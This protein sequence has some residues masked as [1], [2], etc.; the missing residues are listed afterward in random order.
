M[1]LIHD[2]LCQSVSVLI[3]RLFVKLVLLLT[4]L[5]SALSKTLSYR[6]GETYSVD[7]L[8]FTNGE[9]KKD[10]TVTAMKTSENLPGNKVY[11][12]HDLDGLGWGNLL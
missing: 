4:I 7:K 10:T 2:I 6:N 3:M 9:E 1:I 8:V 5:T 12:F 11:S